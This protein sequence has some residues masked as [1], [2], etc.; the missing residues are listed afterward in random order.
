MCPQCFCETNVGP[1]L[2]GK[3]IT[4]QV[5]NSRADSVYTKPSLKLTAR[6]GKSI[7]G[8][9]VSFWDGAFSDAVLVSESVIYLHL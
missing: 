8:R 6:P 5:S 4:K 7:V 3:S 1:G 2:N 9:Y